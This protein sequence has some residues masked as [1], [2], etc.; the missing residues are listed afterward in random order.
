VIIIHF[1]LQHETALRNQL[2]QDRNDRPGQSQ[3]PRFALN[4][5]AATLLLRAILT[6]L[7]VR[8]EFLHGGFDGSISLFR[9]GSA[10]GSSCTAIGK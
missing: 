2:K 3:P 9:A 8:T 4:L 5:M 6:S 7:R 1:N 10:A